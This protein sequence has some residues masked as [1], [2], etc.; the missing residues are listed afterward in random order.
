MSE[1]PAETPAVAT[2]PDD[3]GQLAKARKEAAGYRERLRAA[4]AERDQIV[5]ERDQIAGRLAGFQRAQIDQL[6]VEARLKPAALWATGVTLADLL[7]D[8]GTVDTTAVTQAIDETRT[9]FGITQGA[10]ATNPTGVA[11]NNGTPIRGEDT[12]TSWSAAL[13]HR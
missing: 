5:Q 12:E 4:E 8:D 2:T 7:T 3:G 11:G 9:T 13:K 10:Q 1:Q 6:A